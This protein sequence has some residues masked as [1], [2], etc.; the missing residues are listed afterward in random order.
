MIGSTS[1]AYMPNW[2]RV[3]NSATP[4]TKLQNYGDSGTSYTRTA[5][6]VGASMHRR[7]F[8]QGATCL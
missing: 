5:M 3:E 6:L 8:N 7:R 1:V 4:R 2:A